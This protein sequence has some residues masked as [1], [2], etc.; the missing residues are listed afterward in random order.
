MRMR[1]GAAALLVVLAAAGRAVLGQQPPQPAAFATNCVSCHGEAG[2][3]GRG[4]ALAGNRRVGSM[5]DPELQ[6]LIRNGT[7]NGMPA[8]GAMPAADMATLLAYLRALNAAP[9]A[10]VVEGDAAAGEA[11]FFGK[12][13]CATCHLALGRGSATGPDLSNVGRQMTAAELTTALVDPGASIARGYAS[14]RVRTKDGRTI[15]GFV[16]NEGNHVLPLQTLDGRLVV[17]DKRTATITRETASV[18]PALRATPDERRDLVAY[19]SRLRGGVP[20]AASAAASPEAAPAATADFDEV[21][22][23]RAG[24]WPTY[25]GRLDGNRYSSSAQ[26]NAANV[27]GLSLQWVHSLR[28]FENEM[29]PLVFD[30]IMF[31]TGPNQVSALDAASG[32]EIWRYTRA[33]TPGLRGDA[34]R[35]LNRGVAVLGPR[36]FFVTD[37]AHLLALSR[38]NGALLWEAVLPDDPTPSYGGTMAPL[39]VGDLVIAGVSGGDEG[40]RGFVAA[41]HA[42][43]GTQAWRFWTIPGPGMPGFDTWRGAVDLRHRGGSTW[44]AGSYD[45]ATGTLF[46]PVGNPFPDTDGSEREGDNLYTDSMLALDAKTGQLRWHYQF[47][48]HDLWDWD[49][50]EPA[51]LVDTTYR[52]GPRKLLLQANRNGFFYVLDRTNGQVLLAKPFVQKMTW[53]SG[54]GADGRPQVLPGHTPTLAGVETCPAIRGAANW[55]ATSFSPLTHLF[56]VMTV[57]NCGVYR[58]SQFGTGRGRAAENA[59]PPPPR[60]PT[61]PAGG[62][63][64]GEP[65]GGFIGGR[66]GGSMVLRALDIETGRPVWEVPQTGNSNNYAGTLSTAGG[67]VFYGQASGEFAAVD[68]RTGAHLW[69]FETHE[70]WKS[71]PMTYT[72][73]GRQYVSITA[74]ANVLTFALPAAPASKPPVRPKF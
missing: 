53:A 41:Y 71:S 65:N 32:R 55:M 15:R 2:L 60:P 11:F 58:S 33:R 8:F 40:I 25:H 30:G 73:N 63:N 34:A 7:G 35:G 14:V 70:A 3:G 22:H 44:L 26:I 46:W 4:P 56:Y 28:G 31:I 10:E 12:G 59:A 1:D 38:V 13:Q 9:A 72:A 67:V 42:S 61:P 45:P 37:N 27:K 29:T 51:V 47:T 23:P 50:Q 17:I 16:R 68:A 39:V 49:A 52:G 74:G 69:H 18:M 62:E 36:V 6:S 66:T 24:D 19:L 48:P 21:L 64:F 5:A 57:E 20:P 54:I 43:T